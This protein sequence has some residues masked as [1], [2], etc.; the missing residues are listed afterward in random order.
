MICSLSRALVPVRKMRTR[1]PLSCD[2]KLRPYVGPQFAVKVTIWRHT[3]RKCAAERVVSIKEIRVTTDAPQN[4]SGCTATAPCMSHVSEVS[5]AGACRTS[6]GPADDVASSTQKRHRDL[7]E[8]HRPS[9]R[10][11][12]VSRYLIE[13]KPLGF[14]ASCCLRPA[15]DPGRDL[16][17]A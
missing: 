14:N 15:S 8:A 7:R 13:S 16:P 2:M 11:K 17:E 5:I 6:L 9:M 1:A 10:P 12:R 4:L 3:Q